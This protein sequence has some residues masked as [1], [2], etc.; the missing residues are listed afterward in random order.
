MFVIWYDRGK[1]RGY[2]RKGD[3]TNNFV[4]DIEDA[5]KFPTKEAAV[6]GKPGHHRDMGGDGYH[7]TVMPYRKSGQCL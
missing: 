2:V 4:R 7:G 5:T 6:A 3:G 1:T